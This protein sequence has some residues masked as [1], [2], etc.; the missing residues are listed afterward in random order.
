MGSLWVGGKVPT[1]RLYRD[2]R[3]VT[4]AVVPKVFVEGADLERIDFGEWD[5]A[6]DVP[7]V[8]VESSRPEANGFLIEGFRPVVFGEPI[9]PSGKGKGLLLLGAFYLCAVEERLEEILCRSLG[10]E[11]PRD[12]LLAEELI[13]VGELDAPLAGEF[14]G[15]DLLARTVLIVRSL[16]HENSL[17]ESIERPGAL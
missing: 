17:R 5:S 15:E 3:G 8:V 1:V 9:K 10:G 11:D 7:D 13:H 4:D 6:E 14:P 2:Y 16:R 12:A